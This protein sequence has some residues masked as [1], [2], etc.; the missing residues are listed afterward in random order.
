[1]SILLVFFHLGESKKFPYASCVHIMGELWI[2]HVRKKNYNKMP[3]RKCKYPLCFFHLGKNN[4][5]PNAFCVCYL[6][7]FWILPIRNLF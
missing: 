7:K 3:K 2:I 6:G 1:M 4:V 5:F